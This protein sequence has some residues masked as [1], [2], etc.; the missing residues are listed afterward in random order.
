MDTVTKIIKYLHA[1]SAGRI[2]IPIKVAEKLIDIVKT[3]NVVPKSP[4]V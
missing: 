4:Y 2:D 3:A 1:V